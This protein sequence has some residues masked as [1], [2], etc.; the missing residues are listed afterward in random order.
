MVNTYV[1][2]CSKI[3]N[4]IDKKFKENDWVVVLKEDSNY[5]KAEKDLPQRVTGCS[6]TDPIQ[7]EVISDNGSHQLFE[8]LRSATKEELKVISDSKQTAI[9]LLNKPFGYSAIANRIAV[10]AA[11]EAP[12]KTNILIPEG[13][14]K[15]LTATELSRYEV[16]AVGTGVGNTVSGFTFIPT[17]GQK[18][19]MYTNAAEASIIDKETGIQF[20]IFNE[21]NII[22]SQN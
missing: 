3:I 14:Q 18:L 22:L 6:N 13:L 21:R 19:M 10:K 9:E 17:L 15:S 5:S 1:S 2:L 7:Y 12:K 20:F 11:P 16:V 8:K 4:M